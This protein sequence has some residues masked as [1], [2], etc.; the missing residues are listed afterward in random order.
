MSVLVKARKQKPLKHKLM[1]AEEFFEFARR[2]ENDQRFFELVRGE[3]IELS[4][5][6]RLHGSVCG[7][8]GTRLGV[9]SQQKRFGD[10]VTNDAGLL[11]ERDPDTVR[12]PDIAFFAEELDTESADSYSEMPP[13]LAVEVLSPTDLAEAVFEK[14]SQYLA[15]GV[16]LVWIV[17]PKNRTVTVHR[18]DKPLRVF[19]ENDTITGEEF[20]AG[21]RCQVAEFF[22]P[23]KAT[24]KIKRKLRNGKA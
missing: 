8:I 16:K 5:P 20:L 15:S 10:V 3:V 14:I 23:K 22:P 17:N 13:L 7:R 18:T 4:V 12:G 19:H 6:K 2:S 24:S 21:F 9:F 1:T 11:L